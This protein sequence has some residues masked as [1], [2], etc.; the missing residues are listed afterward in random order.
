MLEAS[1]TLRSAFNKE[2]IKK[3]ATLEITF[4]TEDEQVPHNE[5]DIEVTAQ[6]LR[7]QGI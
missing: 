6:Y 1:L 3:Q 5:Q 4:F 2:V 7:V